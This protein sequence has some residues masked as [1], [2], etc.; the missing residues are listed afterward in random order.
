[1]GRVR[2]VEQFCKA[3]GP[4]GA[5]FL[6]TVDGQIREEGEE[7]L[8]PLGV[9]GSEEGWALGREPLLRQGRKDWRWRLVSW[10][11]SG[12]LP[13]SL[14][15]S[16]LFF[17]FSSAGFWNVLSEVRSGPSGIPRVCVRPFSC[18]AMVRVT[19]PQYPE[20]SG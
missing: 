8:S 16:F 4:R 9:L 14:G 12:G 18:F 1:M 2:G 5:R 11:G 17:F 7:A 13:G 6:M 19:G 20:D 15:F 10:L 3:E